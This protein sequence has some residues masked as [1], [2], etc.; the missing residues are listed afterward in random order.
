[1]K[2]ELASILLH[3]SKEPITEQSSLSAYLVDVT[4]YEQMLERMHLLEGIAKKVFQ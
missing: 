3:P 4:D 2:T 1:M